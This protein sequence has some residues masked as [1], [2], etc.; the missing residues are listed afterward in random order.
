MKQ[1]LQASNSGD[2]ISPKR[3]RNDRTAFT[4]RSDDLQDGERLRTVIDTI[5]GLVWSAFPDGGVELCNQRWL[6]YTG[7]SSSEVRAADWMAAIHPDDRSDLMDKWRV[8]LTQGESFEAE[9]RMRRADSS[10]RWFLIQAVPLRDSGGE[11]VRWYGTNTDIEELKL[12]QEEL[13]RQTSRL[14]ELFEQSPEAVAVVSADDRIVRV[15]K[16]FIRMFGYEPDELLGR[17]LN[18]LIVPEAELES[19]RAYTRLLKQGGRVEVETIRRRKDGTEIYVSLLAVS[20]R[21]TSGEQ[22]VNYAIY[23]DITERKRSEE[24]L[25]ESEARFQVMA[26]TA[27][28]M[29]WTT[30]TDAVCNYFNKPWLDFTGRTMEQEVGTGWVEGV[31]PDDVQGCF[32]GFLPAFHARKPFR[33]EYRLKRAD[34]EYRW[35][36]ESGIPRYTGGGEFAG[37]IGS[38]VDITDR[39]QAES[40]L[41]GEKRVLEMLAKGDS[42]P[43]IL[44]SLCELVEEQANGV[45]A[46]ILL[47]EDNRLRHGAAPSL[48]KAYTN[49]ID[50]G[51][52]GPSAGS[53]GTAAYRGQQVIVEDIATDPL[54]AAYRDLALP[55]SLRSCWSTP[56]FSSQGKVIATCGMYHREPRR[57]SSRDQ[58]IIE[59]I[60]H[61]A[62]VAIERKLAQ[63]ALRRSEA[64]LAEAQ[65]LTHTG[66]WARD[67]SAH[68]VL[69]WSEETFRILGLEPQHSTPDGDYSLLVMHPEDRDRVNQLRE[70]AMR[71][72]VDFATDYR[73]VLP[74]GTVK[75]LHIIGHPVF[76]E[77]GEA[78][79]YV[80][81]VMDI[82]E[83]KQAEEERERLRQLQLDL[84]HLN[85][86]TTM[87]ELTAS[88]AHEIKQPISAAILDAGTCVEW[89]KRDKPDVEEARNAVSRIIQDATRASEIINRIRFLFK[90]GEPQ[91]ELLDVNDV[92]REMI[93]LLRREAGQHSISIHTE[94]AA[95]L[96]LISA[97]RVQLQQVFMNLMLNAIDAM[98]E[99]S[100]SGELTIKSQHHPG[101]QLEISLSDTGA[102]LP[103]DQGDKIF[104]AFFTTKPQGTGMGLSIS[105]SI[106]ESHGGRLWATANSRQGATFHFTI[107]SDIKAA[108]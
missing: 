106:I 15:N 79:E 107:P 84:A 10:F 47:L 27:P 66:S 108:A 72:K 83:R 50:G 20:V 70:K 25:R 38:N 94:L 99:R 29:I 21:T 55:H 49:A 16:E 87:G 53:C 95:D 39:R 3:S 76:D 13:R 103:A 35:V 56:V 7:M 17:P 46:S 64:Y 100:G 24:R 31:H 1:R 52:I 63:E 59:Q 65:R 61:L 88:L 41:A 77:T 69:Y 80:G 44:H 78:P 57:P 91:R 2:A 102:G 92:I 71:E 60:S 34:G 67:V 89:L 28:V 54:W 82:T 11:V 33:M 48:P 42:L 105:R 14:D 90:K 8:S 12:A 58:E 74:E 4:E 9:A 68:K 101:D 32:D 36:M 51:V 98:K 93:V 19:S 40:L 30:G 43:E 73:I 75:H 97:D 45:L 81:T 85:R 26:D 62:G 23:R 18:D 86:V 104:D 37:Y 22:V 5:P 96:P 6:Q